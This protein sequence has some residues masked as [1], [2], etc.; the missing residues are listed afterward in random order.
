LT[1]KSEITLYLIDNPNSTTRQV[2]EAFP[3]FPMSS[4]RGRLSELR[5]A[6]L[7]IKA[8]PS[9]LNKIKEAVI[10]KLKEV[11]KAPEEEE[12]IFRREIVKVLV[13]C[14]DEPHRAGHG[15]RLYAL[16][17]SNDEI[18]HFDDLVEAI[19]L[20]EEI[21]QG[22]FDLTFQFLED[23]GEQ[24]APLTKFKSCL[25]ASSYGYDDELETDK[26]PFE[27]PDIE[28]GEE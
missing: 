13:Y 10:E 26:P 9:H 5:K 23:K 17:Y 20:S 24:D 8:N 11:I 25:Q 12:E 22:V 14:P 4:V 21:E 7:N 6:G 28:V 3:Q 18:D 15:H 16:T 19:E 2:I 27:F 1:Q